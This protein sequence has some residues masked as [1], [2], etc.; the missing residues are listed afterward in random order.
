MVVVSEYN[1]EFVLSQAVLPTA[2]VFIASI[3][4]LDEKL[5]PQL[6][7]P[8]LSEFRLMFTA[9]EKGVT[10]SFLKAFWNCS[11]LQKVTLQLRQQSIL[12]FDAKYLV[13]R[14]GL[15]EHIK[16]LSFYGDGLQGFK[17]GSLKRGLS[18]HRGLVSLKFWAIRFKGTHLFTDMVL[19]LDHLRADF[20]ALN[21]EDESKGFM[22]S[23]KLQQIKVANLRIDLGYM[24][25]Q[26]VA[27]QRAKMLAAAVEKHVIDAKAVSLGFR[28]ARCRDSEIGFIIRMMRRSY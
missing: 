5:V 7:H 18:L 8:H 26:S 4:D 19:N 15:S 14:S 3:A 17:I 21:D 24:H 1:A 20:D 25:K 16:H 11:S 13:Y 28:Y 6:F 10:E 2:V 9:I 23:L 12:P 27:L 22:L